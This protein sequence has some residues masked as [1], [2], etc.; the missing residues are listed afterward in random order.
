MN[1]SWKDPDRP[2]GSDEAAKQPPKDAKKAG[3]K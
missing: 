3:K 2:P 1:P